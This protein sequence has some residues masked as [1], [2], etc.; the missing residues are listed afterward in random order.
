[1][2]NSTLHHERLTRLT[3]HGRQAEARS[4][5]LG[6]TEWRDDLSHLSPMRQAAW[7]RV[8]S[9]IATTEGL[10]ESLMQP[11]MLA[12]KQPGEDHTEISEYLESHAVDERRHH[13]MLCGY[14]KQT[15]GYVKKSRTWSDRVIYDRVLPLMAQAFRYRPLYGFALLDTYENFATEFYAPLRTQAQADGAQNILS[16]LQAIEKDELRHVAGMEYLLDRELARQGGLRRG[17]RAAIATLLNVLVLDV[18]FSPWALHNR[19]IRAHL[20]ELGVPPEGVTAT[21]RRMR[22]HTLARLTASLAEKSEGV[23][24]VVP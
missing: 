14:L 4:R 21:A 2:T 8:L 19:E 17:D 1:M 15:F 12:Y 22:D 18:D 11:L 16:L 6:M 3:R 24:H 7:R 5:E 23:S 10:E 20:C 13:A 9:S